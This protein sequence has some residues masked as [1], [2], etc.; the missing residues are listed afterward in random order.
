VANI[1]VVRADEAAFYELGES[2]RNSEPLQALDVSS[3]AR[4][5]QESEADAQK[6]SA[7]EAGRVLLEAGHDD[8]ELDECAQPSDDALLE[9]PES[10][11]IVEVFDEDPTK[12]PPI[13]HEDYRD[14]TA[15]DE[16]ARGGA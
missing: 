8:E 14:V 9:D 6:N 3:V 15:D 10:F 5:F 11:A 4:D 12:E 7:A 13:D 1:E 16:G 2:R